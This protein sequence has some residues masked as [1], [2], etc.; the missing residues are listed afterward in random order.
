MKAFAAAGESAKAQPVPGSPERIRWQALCR[1]AIEANGAYMKELS[2]RDP[3]EA[4][5]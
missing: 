1:E 5:S 2:R 4:Q 3:D